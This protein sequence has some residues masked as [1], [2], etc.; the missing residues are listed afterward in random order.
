MRLGKFSDTLFP[1]LLGLSYKVAPL[2]FSE[3]DGADGVVCGVECLKLRS[4]LRVDDS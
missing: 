2:I 4:S 1:H 3:L